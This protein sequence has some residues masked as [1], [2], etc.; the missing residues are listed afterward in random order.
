MEGEEARDGNEEKIKVVEVMIVIET[1]GMSG[2]RRMECNSW[3]G[4]ARHAPRDVSGDVLKRGT[5]WKPLRQASYPALSV[6]QCLKWREA[7]SDSNL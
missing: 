4:S 6:R 7:T 1:R 3:K 2:G 5:Y